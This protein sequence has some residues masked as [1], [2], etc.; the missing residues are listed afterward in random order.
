MNKKDLLIGIGGI[1]LIVAFIALIPWFFSMQYNYKGISHFLVITIDREAPKEHLGS[2]EECEVYI[3]KLNIDE[4][5][6]RTIDAKN[7]PIKEALEKKLVWL[8]DW[9]RYAFRKIKKGDTEILRYENY[10]IA[11]TDHECLIRPIY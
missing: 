1:I 10:E 2:L 8:S 3:E 7:M 9:R 6:F 4:T 11:V 5:V